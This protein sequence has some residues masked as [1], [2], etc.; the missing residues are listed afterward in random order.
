VVFSNAFIDSAV[1]LLISQGQLANA[2]LQDP[3][4]TTTI[5]NTANIQVA[6]YLSNTNINAAWT[7]ANTARTQANNAFAKAN[8]ALA[9]TTSYTLTITDLTITGN[10]TLSGATSV[11]NL[12]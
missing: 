11:L 5:Y 8:A 12:L 4:V 1:T 3:N 9:N 6:N 2:V 10:V 7:Q